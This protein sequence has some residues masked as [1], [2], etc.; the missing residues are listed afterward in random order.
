MTFKKT[1]GEFIFNVAKKAF[2]G[3]KQK[4]TGTEVIKNVPIAK[5]IDTKKAIEQK[6]VKTVD[7]A[8]KDANVP[9]S[10]RNQQKKSE[11]KR[12]EGKKL[13]GL[14]YRLDEL[15]EKVKKRNEGSKKL[16]EASKG[17][18]FNKGGRVGLKRGTNLMK[19][20]SNVQKI[21]ETF[22]P[23][24]SNPKKSAAKKKK[25]PDLTGDGKVTFADILKG[26]GV[27]RG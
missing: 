27:K 24:S 8:F 22:G 26:R 3:G 11:L 19:R 16:F 15:E 1:A 5:N 17:R 20:K 18:K 6:V 4:T 9:P 14:S 7:K 21:K 10:L 13:K 2:G 23:G 12:E 25:F